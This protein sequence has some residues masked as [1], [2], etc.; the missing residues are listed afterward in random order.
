V[1]LFDQAAEHARNTMMRTLGLLVCGLLAGQ[2]AQ[3]QESGVDPRVGEAKTAC[4][5]GNV[6]KGI[7]LLAELY[8]ATN[9]PI[10][11][12][13]QGRCYHQNAQLVQALSRFKEFL[14]KSKGTPD[15]DVK[16][17]QNYI[18]EIETEQQKERSLSGAASTAT[19]ATNTLSTQAPA[20]EP[21]PGRGLRYAGVGVGIFGV[22]ALASGVV[23]GLLV[24]QTQNQVEDQT[25]SGV[26]DSSAIS[27]KLSDG[28]RYETLQWI[29]YGVGAAAV[30]AGSLLYWM[31]TGSAETSSARVSPMFM[32]NGA[33]ASLQMAF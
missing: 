6:Q 22:A 29:S 13:N 5:A 16:D 31:G 23:F 18:T 4:A 32:T 24:R 33:G 2:V 26:V 20:P 15:E 19:E 14:R 27:G 7:E 12:F 17:A 8:T 21:K 28:Y 30:V 10:W 11:I 3:A 25:K 1:P 9:D